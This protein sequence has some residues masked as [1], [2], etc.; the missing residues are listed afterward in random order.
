MK[1]GALTVAVMIYFGVVASGQAEITDTAIQEFPHSTYVVLRAQVDLPAEGLWHVRPAMDETVVQLYLTPPPEIGRRLIGRRTEAAIQQRRIDQGQWKVRSVYHACQSFAREHA[2]RG[3]KDVDELDAEQ[4]RYVS[5]FL[6]ESPWRDWDAAV[7]GKRPDGPFVFLVPS[8]QFHF[9]DD[10]RIDVASDQRELLA[11]ELRP[12]VQDGRHWVLYTDGT[13]VRETIDPRRLERYQLEIRPIR[14][15]K[16]EPV[17]TVSPTLAYTLVAVRSGPQ[18]QPIDVNFFNSISNDQQKRTWNPAEARRD[19]QVL[20]SLQ[21]ARRFAWQPY[22]RT[23]PAPVL[24][25]WL[26]VPGQADTEQ[27]PDARA[28]LSAFSLLGGRAAIEETLQMQTLQSAEEAGKS[29]VDIASLPGVEVSSH[30]FAQMLGDD[31]GGQ[32]RLADAVPP[33][34]FFVYLAKPESILPLLDR[35]AR[36]LAAAGA[37]WT[38][39]RL[40]YGLANRY[41][42]RLGISRPWLEAVLE[43]GVLHDMAIAL[44]DLLLIDGTDLTVI[45]RLRQPELLVPLLRL[46][47]I[48]GL[49]TDDVVIAQPGSGRETYWALRDDLLC[50]SSHRNELD[51]VLELIAADGAGSLGRSDEFR[52]MLKQVPVERQTRILAY[53]SDSFV[54]RIVGPEVKLGQLRRAQARGRMEWLTAQS[55]LAR[56]DGAA[57]IESVEDLVRMEYVP[58]EFATDDYAIDAEGRVRSKTFGSLESMKTLLDV[59]IRTATPAEAQAY[60]RYVDNYMRYWSEFFDP[61]AIRLNDAPDRS[62]ELTTFI[63]P[64][65]DSSIYNDLREVMLRRED[66]RPLVIP[67]MEPDPV[68]Q[69]SVNLGDR[70]WQEFAGNMSDF[71]RR[72][73]GASPALLDDLG[74]AVHLAVFDADPVIALGSGDVMGAFGG[75]MMGTGSDMLMASAALSLLTRPCTIL[76]ETRDPEQTARYLRQAATVGIIEPRGRRFDDFRA[77]FHQIDNQDRWVWSMDIAG[78]IKLRYG[79]QVAGNYLVVRNIPWSGSDRVVQVEPAGLC[80]AGLSVWPAACELQLP[81][82][83]ASAAEQ[84]RLE[85]MSAIGRLYP[86]IISQVANVQTAEQRHGQLFGFRPLHP[87]SGHWVWHEGTLA[88]SVYGSAQH[89]RQPD[90]DPQRPFGLMQAIESLQLNM[91]FEDAGLRST[92]RWKLREAP[93]HR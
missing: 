34:R 37:G 36:F 23:G 32:L 51:R 25:S 84:E 6:Q 11:L 56:L 70:F 40:D 46:T 55:L 52:Y 19:K 76:V 18:S 5:Q 54:R 83:F 65:I 9:A 8:A 48:R 61:I 82:L 78:V 33:D 89:Q 60:Q 92:I 68:L 69:F 38:G 64:L 71:F 3:P 22:L 57:A 63:L 58:S 20:E 73:G 88:S 77:S 74:P 31:P 87:P 39:N 13:C 49:T 59:P 72:Y 93:P 44:P 24:H 91:Q 16:D 27:T 14:L 81:G 86:L 85:A 45:A 12:Y 41:L 15:N 10:E 66:S 35:G 28:N 43:S 17:E 67:R 21:E 29:T 47:G 79:V 80:S 50:I 1:S 2:G 42:Q 53:F 62:L 7:D 4:H 90:F 30:P 75:S 26:A